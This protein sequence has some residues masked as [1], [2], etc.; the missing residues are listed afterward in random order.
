M[1]GQRE[2]VAGGQLAHRAFALE[3]FVVSSSA[4]S[5][6]WLMCSGWPLALAIRSPPPSYTASDGS[7]PA[8]SEDS[9]S[10]PGA[11]NCAGSQLL[12]LT[13]LACTCRRR[14]LVN[15]VGAVG[16]A[17][18]VEADLGAARHIGRLRLLSKITSLLGLAVLVSASGWS[19]S[20]RQ[21]RPSEASRR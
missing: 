2:G 11:S 19:C 17:H 6:S 21:L 8:S 5:I 1:L 4:C 10:A 3:H 13:A 15:G 14:K 9:C 7:S 20:K 18:A 16:G 12:M